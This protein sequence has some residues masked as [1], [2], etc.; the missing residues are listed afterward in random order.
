M[1]RTRGQKGP[2]TQFVT[3]ADDAARIEAELAKRGM[4]RAEL[5]R[6]VDCTP[7]NLGRIIKP[8][9]R[10]AF[11]PKVFQVLG[12]D[13]AKESGVSVTRHARALA[14]LEQLSA[15]PDRY[16]EA[17]DALRSLLE[18]EQEIETRIARLNDV[19]TGARRK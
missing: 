13:Q 10:S 17:I 15:S 1:S 8:G 2:G 12:I 4:S 3:T 19:V 6:L 14:L 9:R 5:A 16:L 7:S 18:K 11:L